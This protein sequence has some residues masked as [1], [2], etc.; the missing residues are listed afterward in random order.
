MALKCVVRLG[1]FISVMP[2]SLYNASLVGCTSPVLSVLRDMSTASSPFHSQSNV[3]RLCAGVCSFASFQ[4]LPPSVETSTLVIAPAPDQARPVICT[5]PLPGIFM[6][7]EGRVIT[8]LVAHSKW[9][10]RDLPSRSAR[11]RA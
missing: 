9:Y 3:K 5:Y 8:D 6:P 4:L 1:L 11:G 2:Q 10:Q 7:P